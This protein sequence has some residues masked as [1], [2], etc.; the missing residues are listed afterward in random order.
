MSA[1]GRET[2]QVILVTRERLLPHTRDVVRALTRVRGV[3]SVVQNINP[4]PGNVIF[5]AQFVPL[6]RETALVERVDFLKLKTHAGAFLQAN[7]S[8]ARKLY[9]QA[10]QWTA[11]QA[12]DTCID[13]YCGVGALTFYLATAAKH[14]V[15][16]EESPIAIAD[17]KENVRLNGF[18]NIRFHCGR[19]C[20]DVASHCG[21][22]AAA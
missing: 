12:D 5:G 20:G 18:H 4:E 10:L 13:L 15:G 17:A 19:R 3:R 8:V 11:P 6:T 21:A 1:R 16:I 14:V 7:V 9:L 22:L 2:A